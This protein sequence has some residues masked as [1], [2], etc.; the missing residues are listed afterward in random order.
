MIIYNFREK[1]C[2]VPRENDRKQKFSYPESQER[3]R[4]RTL[5]FRNGL[6]NARRGGCD[7]FLVIIT[8]V[9]SEPQ[10][11][12]GEL[13]CLP[14]YAVILPKLLRLVTEETG[15]AL[16]GG[17]HFL[18]SPVVERENT[19]LCSV[20]GYRETTKLLTRVQSKTTQ[21]WELGGRKE[22]AR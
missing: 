12:L 16:S 18:V 9:H 17:L 13:S 19:Q 21:S 15:W 14:T 3:E 10:I 6:A 1:D 4:D 5:W 20:Y 2:G 11:C 22:A 8:S 7:V